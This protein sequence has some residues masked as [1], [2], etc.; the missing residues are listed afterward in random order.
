MII[1]TEEHKEKAVELLAE[2][3]ENK[4]EQK[5]YR[6]NAIANAVLGGVT[7]VSGAVT[8][9]NTLLGIG[10]ALCAKVVMDDILSKV[11]V[12]R[13]NTANEK[14]VKWIMDEET[15]IPDD[16]YD[17]Q[18]KVSKQQAKDYFI[19]IGV[20][21]THRFFKNSVKERTNEEVLKRAKEKFLSPTVVI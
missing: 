20:A 6:K 5:L 13:A 15:A 16:L 10:T 3:Y 19:G 1:S 21:F 2:F 14:L 9:N 17:A 12:N 7:Y 11:A 4:A 8:G 18:E